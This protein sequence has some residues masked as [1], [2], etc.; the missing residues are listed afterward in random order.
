MEVEAEFQDVAVM[1]AVPGHS[2]ILARSVF[3]G[4]LPGLD[5]ETTFA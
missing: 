3:T 2:Q 1:E 4:A 5:V